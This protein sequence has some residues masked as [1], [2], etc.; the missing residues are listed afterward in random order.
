MSKFD[1][2]IKEEK[3]RA[4]EAAE[5]ENAELTEKKRK[6]QEFNELKARYESKIKEY[7]EDLNELFPKVKGWKEAHYFTNFLNI[8]RNI[9]YLDLIRVVV[10]EKGDF[11]QWVNMG[12]LTGP[13]SMDEAAERI[14]VGFRYQY[15]DNALLVSDVDEMV[16]GYFAKALEGKV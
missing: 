15:N 7:L 9:R 10:T 1:Q 3:I 5:I 12:V 13:L 8:R 16:R 11:Y 2:L 6:E 4:N 14:F